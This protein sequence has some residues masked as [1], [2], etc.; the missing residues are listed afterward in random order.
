MIINKK[1]W[2]KNKARQLLLKKNQFAILLCIGIII[3][4]VFSMIT[5]NLA[6]AEVT[7]KPIFHP[8]EDPIAPTNYTEIQY[9]SVCHY[10]DSGVTMSVTVY[11]Q[12]TTDITYYVTGSSAKY[13]GIEGWA[14]FDKLENNKVHGHYP[15][16][17]TLHK[18]GQTYS[19]FWVDN[20]TKNPPD[21]DHPGGSANQS[22]T[23]LNNPPTAPIIDGQTSGKPG[24]SYEYTF[25]STDV[26]GDKIFYYVDWGD[27]TNSG[28]IGPFNSGETTTKSHSWSGE[29]TYTIKAQA[30]D[31]HGA[32]SGWG[33]FE[34]SIPRSIP[35]IV[36][37][38]SLFMKFLERFLHLLPIL[39]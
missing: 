10:T 21:I 16:Y 35:R 15:G 36:T 6:S 37:V 1:F 23:T 30:R 34:V 26:E 11:G 33:T 3:T 2:T 31:E 39:K 4:L 25:V 27:G 8:H 19:V 24:T 28:W 12:T 9:C 38:N 5:I 14:V 13:E 22:I 17:F 20:G 29:N 32:I 7:E 18:D